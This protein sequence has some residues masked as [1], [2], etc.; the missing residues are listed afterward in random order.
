MKL[1]KKLITCFAFLLTVF[2]TTKAQLYKIDL[3]GKV[4][5]A[6]L[7][8]EGTVTGKHSFWNE[9]HTIIYTSNTVHVYKLFKGNLIT[10]DIEVITR[11]GRW[12]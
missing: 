9:A 5:K 11:G 12:V 4:N 6:S 7:I 2:S 10:A 8:V 1:T 3:A